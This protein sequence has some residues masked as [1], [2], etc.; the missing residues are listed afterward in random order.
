M[1]YS[2][3][4]HTPIPPEKISIG[5]YS[6]NR[7]GYAAPVYFR[8]QRWAGVYRKTGYNRSLASDEQK[9]PENGDVWQGKP[10]P[11]AAK[12]FLKHTRN[13]GHLQGV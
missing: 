9:N 3:V 13:T 12:R 10:F 2:P 6:Q 7:G 8:C 5:P 4:Y 1:V 11:G